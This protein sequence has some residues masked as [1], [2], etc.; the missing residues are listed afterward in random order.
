MKI[1]ETEWSLNRCKLEIFL[2]EIFLLFCLLTCSFRSGQMPRKRTTKFIE[3]SGVC[4]TLIFHICTYRLLDAI[5]ASAVPVRFRDCASLVS[6]SIVTMSSILRRSHIRRPIQ[7]DRF[8][9]VIYV[10][11]TALCSQFKEAEAAYKDMIRS[12]ERV[13]TSVLQAS[14]LF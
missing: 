8:E 10:S 6:I 11:I 7:Y 12:I 14:W 3:L 4:E 1:A 5:G 13:N 2:H 9:N